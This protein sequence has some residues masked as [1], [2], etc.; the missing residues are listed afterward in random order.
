MSPTICEKLLRNWIRG[1]GTEWAGRAIEKK[2]NVFSNRIKRSKLTL[3]T[4]RY[5][6]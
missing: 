4:G 6:S 3:D 5:V 2:I 1:L